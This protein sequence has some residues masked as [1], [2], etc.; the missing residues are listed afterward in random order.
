[1][2]LPQRILSLWLPLLPTERI[3]RH[4]FGRSWRSRV[5]RDTPPLVVSH[6]EDN[7]QRIA[8]LDAQASALRLKPGMG[9]AEA[10]AM[11]PAIEVVEADPEADRRLLES[12]ADWCDRYTPLVAIDGAD[13][14]LL[15]I[16]GCAHLFGGEAA[17]L[18]QLTGALTR[19]GFAVSA[20]IAATSICARTL[21]RCAPGTIVADG[22]EAEA[23]ASLL[24]MRSGWATPG[25]FCAF[26]AF[27]S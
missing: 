3:L 24:A 23:I 15:D 17:L 9:I 14:L 22:G 7:A 26:T 19:Q 25:S 6:R 27:S 8:S 21:T 20:A 5:L 2:T 11:H 10:R 1:M 18:R 13:G 4:R 16:T 12:L